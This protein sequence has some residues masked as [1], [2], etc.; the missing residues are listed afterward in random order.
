MKVTPRND[1]VVFRRVQRGTTLKGIHMPDKSLEGIDH[2]VEA[3][4]PKVEDLK[5]GDKVL[6][7]GK[8][9]E[10]YGELPN[11]KG[12]YLTRQNNIAIVMEY[13]EK[14]YEKLQ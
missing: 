12:L 13:E 10:D 4:G 11:Q 14:D 9:G 3:I 7:L 5:V 6:I 1:Y 2:V 8:L